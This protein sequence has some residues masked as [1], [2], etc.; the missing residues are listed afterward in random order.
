MK[1][2]GDWYFDGYEG[3]SVP[4]PDGRP[5]RQLV[6]T[7]EYYGFSGV[8]KMRGQKLW[9]TLAV[10]VYLLCYVSNS[11][12]NGTM[13]HTAYVGLPVFLSVVP[14]VWLVIGL[15]CF[16]A[17]GP[18]MTA[19]TLYSSL[20]RMKRSLWFITPLLAVGSGGCVVC[21]IL[22]PSL[23]RIGAEWLYLLCTFIALGAV[24]SMLVLMRKNPV[25]IVRDP[26]PDSQRMH[27]LEE[28]N[29]AG[30]RRRF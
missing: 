30:K 6:Y 9:Y 23:I 15:V 29:K 10:A 7:G 5:R 22:Q 11:L 26:E 12:S 4:N 20:R 17:A 28:K 13:A 14:A 27:E 18:E 21:F 25:V 1:G 2:R 3:R 16:W 8:G 24:C 19:R